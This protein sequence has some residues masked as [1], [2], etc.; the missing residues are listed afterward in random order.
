MKH[1]QSVC[2][3]KCKEAKSIAD[4]EIWERNKNK[5]LM[6]QHVSESNRKFANHIGKLFQ[7]VFVD[8]K[9]LTLSAFSW[10]SRYIATEAGF[11]FDFN[12]S[13]VPNIPLSTNLQYVNPPGHLK[14][15]NSIV[16]SYSDDFKERIE[17]ARS[18]SLHI[19][20]SVDRT[21]IDKIYIILK[22]VSKTGIPESFFLGI[23]NQTESGAEGLLAAVKRGIIENSG[24]EIFDIVMSLI[25]SICTDGASINTGSKNG[26]WVLFEN[27][28]K[29]HRSNF[30][31]LKL[32]CS[33]HRIDLVW[34]DMTDSVTEISHALGLLSSIASY[35]NNSALRTE[36]LKRVADES[37]LSLLSI[38]KLFDIRWTEWTFVTVVNTLRSWNAL[39]VYFEKHRDADLQA[40]GF[41]AFLTSFENLEVLSFLGDLLSMYHRYHK[42]VQSD[43]LN[44]ITM[45]NHISDLTKSL[46]NLKLNNIIGGWEELL[47]ESIVVERDGDMFLKGIKLNVSQGRRRNRDIATIRNSTVDSIIM[48][49]GERFEMDNTLIHIVKPF[50]KFNESTDIR[51]LHRTIVPDLSLQSLSIQF[52]ELVPDRQNRTESV[53]DTIKS[54]LD[55]ENSAEF[56]CVITALCRI[57]NL[58]PQS[59]DVERMIKANNSLKTNE[60]NRI[61]L[62]T[63]NKYMFVHYNMPVLE[64][65]NPRKAVI[66]FLKEKNRRV[67]EI[68]IQK[69]KLKQQSFYR[70]VFENADK[71]EN[72]HYKQASNDNIKF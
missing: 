27:E 35:F 36:N 52:N 34:K 16:S 44:I 65:W 30:P 58:S 68:S 61:C 22:T 47:K 67:N 33:A 57:Q 45:S 60:R 72:D 51:L 70:G 50:V 7:Q 14:M 43:N 24:T 56:D 66:H 21:Q 32:W 28:L 25:T 18:C 8:A 23:G 1:F 53:L 55:R 37:H 39:C 4:S 12:N 40:P 13:N 20:G 38:P 54:L 69:E 63:E 26:L 6:D 71:T 5:Q 11:H 2:H 64:N 46:Q 10:P 9:K 59:A 42:R 17:S 62:V 31:F 15:L 29:K 49:L 3:Q 19:D 41:F 48:S